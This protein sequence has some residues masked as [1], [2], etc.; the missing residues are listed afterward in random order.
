M[1]GL[2]CNNARYILKKQYIC[3]PYVDRSNGTAYE[4]EV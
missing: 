4:E 2:P 3:I 1:V